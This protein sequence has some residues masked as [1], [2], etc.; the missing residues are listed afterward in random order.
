MPRPR[1]DLSYEDFEKLVAEAVRTTT[2][3][4]RMEIRR[5]HCQLKDLNGQVDELKRLLEDCIVSGK[6]F[7]TTYIDVQRVPSHPHPA[8]P[9]RY[10]KKSDRHEARPHRSTSR[11]RNHE[12]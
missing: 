12:K 3:K 2:D 11:L 10:Y 9:D 4:H 7:T 5:L 6:S 8:K 1:I